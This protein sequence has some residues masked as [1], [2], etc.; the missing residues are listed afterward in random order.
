MCL[1][2]NNGKTITLGELIHDIN[3]MLKQNKGSKIYVPMYQRN[4]KW[5]KKIAGDFVSDLIES[6]KGSKT[7]SIALFTLYIDPKNNIQVIDGQ[8]RMITLLLMFT[9][10][11]KANDFFTLEFER[12]FSLEEKETRRN[13]IENINTIQQNTTTEDKEETI[14]FNKKAL[15]DKRRLLYNYEEIAEKV[16]EIKEKK[17]EEFIQHIK[18]NVKLLLHIT[19]DEPV[20]EFLNLNYN[21]TKFSVCDRVRSA[22]ITYPTFNKIEDD[23]KNSIASTLDCSNYKK[24]VSVLFEELTRLLYIDDIYDTVKLGYKDPEKTNENRINIMFCNLVE[25]NS[26]GYMN[27]EKI[28]KDKIS[29]LHKLAYYKK[30]LQEL[31][32]DNQ[33]YQLHRAFRNF[34]AHKGVKFF[35]LLDNYINKQKKCNLYDILHI[36]HSIDKCIFDY[37]QQHLTGKDTY[38]INSYFEVLSKNNKPKEE[39]SYSSLLE[40]KLDDSDD[41]N[42]DNNSTEKYF[43]I[44]KSILETIVQSSGKYVLYRYINERH[45]QNNNIISF[46]TLLTFEEESNLKNRDNQ[47]ELGQHITVKE[48]LEDYKIIIP[49]IQRDYCMGSHL[50]KQ[51]RKDILDYIISNY[52]KGREI[53]LSA[54]TVF[55]FEQDEKQDKKQNIYIYDGQQRIFTLICILK[56]LD[57]KSNINIEFE[58][59]EKFQENIDKF[60]NSESKTIPEDNYVSKSIYNLKEDNYVSKSIYNLE[61]VL[62]F[63]LRDYEVYHIPYF[64][65]DKE[66]KE[67]DDFNKYILEKIKFDVI[68]VNGELS[69]AE[70][71]FV[72]INDGVQL[73]PYEIFKCKINAKFEELIKSLDNCKECDSKKFYDEWIS[74]IDNEWLDYFYKYNDVKYDD[75]TAVEELMEIR[76]IEF[77]CRMIYWEKYIDSNNK[78]E[79]HPLDLENFKSLTDEIGDIDT[80]IDTLEIED[81]ERISNIMDN[82]IELGLKEVNDENDEC[83]TYGDIYVEDEKLCYIHIMP[84]YKENINTQMCKKFINCFLKSLNKENEGNKRDIVM[85]SILNHLNF[86]HKDEDIEVI[87]NIIYIWNNKIIDERPF[88]YITPNFL[89]KYENAILPVPD[90]YYNHYEGK[91]FINIYQCLPYNYIKESK[92]NYY[93]KESKNKM[94]DEILKSYIKEVNNNDNNDKDGKVNN[95]C[96]STE[97]I[98]KYR[99]FYL[100]GKDWVVDTSKEGYSFYRVKDGAFIKIDS[101]N[102]IFLKNG[103]RRWKGRFEMNFKEGTLLELKEN[104]F[105]I[106]L[107]EW[108]DNTHS[109][110]DKELNYDIQDVKEIGKRQS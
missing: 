105:C 96:T 57:N 36:E 6:Y 78:K 98:K 47:S 108:D 48:L 35:D 46:P 102:G 84:K 95:N 104:K 70:Q 29:I 106:T 3:D 52:K 42:K 75:E 62:D 90:Y 99:I 27:F 74:K 41:N 14:K 88:A 32:S 109:Y 18:K 103:E 54:I 17:E 49:V 87:K 59:R 100:Y 30:M 82:L 68:T 73:V 55:V 86:E 4:Y 20:S 81:F 34:Y 11:D 37:M 77:C 110:K 23:K 12:D 92:N 80:F 10:L 76:F 25:E 97:N 38:F 26:N 43:T 8:Q 31:E 50:N 93:I 65:P 69:T 101:N 33:N 72:E 22:L 24:G 1:K 9:A 60:F 13:F 39:D 15:S 83:I 67:K 2:G 45:K 44:D 58:Y 107:K 7:K 63:K 53:T 64:K 5:N 28:G 61:D 94:Y 56:L 40:E 89:G 71:F 85:W 16:K 91:E 66:K 51:G 79:N 21:K 19:E